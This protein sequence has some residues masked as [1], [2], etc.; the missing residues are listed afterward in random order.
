MVCIPYDIIV[1]ISAAVSGTV[2]LSFIGRGRLSTI[3][4]IVDAIT[5]LKALSLTG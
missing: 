1:R 2:R 3:I 4:L 5:A